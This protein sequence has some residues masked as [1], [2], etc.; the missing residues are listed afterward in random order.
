MNSVC[1][2]V[3]SCFH[4]Y[5][6]TVKKL[7]ESCKKA[8]IPST[9][10]YVV[11]GESKEEKDIFFNEDYNIIFCKY[12]NIDY[13]GVLYFTQNDSG[14]KELQ[15][16][17][18]FFYTHDTVEFLEDFWVKINAYSNNC[19]RYIKLDEL[20]S[21]NMGLI[22][23]KWFIENKKELFSYFIN[24]DESLK[25]NYKMASYPNEIPNKD[26][27]YSKFN[28]LPQWLNED[29]VFLFTEYHHPIGDVFQN[30]GIEQYYTNIYNGNERLASVYKEPGLIKYNINHGKAKVRWEMNL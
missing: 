15:K 18:H 10:I 29:C 3:N 5:E 4:F 12:I 13:N 7:I 8:K 11:I 1:I 24:Y 27:I 14:L 30:Y 21:K 23:V 17:T 19:D 6:V 16:Y 2:I 22:N 28:N 26:L 25:L 9:S 20:G